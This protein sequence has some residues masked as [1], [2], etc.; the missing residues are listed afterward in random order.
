MHRWPHFSCDTASRPAGG[1]DAMLRCWLQQVK[2][3]GGPQLWVVCRPRASPPGRQH[4]DAGAPAL[5]LTLD[6]LREMLS[7][8]QTL[9]IWGAGGATPGKFL[10][11][12]RVV[13]C[14]TSTLVRPNRVL[15]VPASS[16]S[17]SA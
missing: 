14:D 15:V 12:L 4:G 2:S 10:L 1:S 9:C 3:C 7:S 16:V 6:D 13:T 5:S 8:N 11:G 17:L